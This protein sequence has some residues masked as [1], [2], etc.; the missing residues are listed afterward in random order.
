MDSSQ[1]AAAAAAAA[2]AA[3]GSG[4]D[5]AEDSDVQAALKVFAE[6]ESETY[7]PATSVTGMLGNLWA[8][9]PDVPVRGTLPTA[10]C[11][12]PASPLSFTSD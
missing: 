2:G 5:G 8:R 11:L 3:A 9:I 10:Y 6:K 1:A 7:E 4:G 12:L